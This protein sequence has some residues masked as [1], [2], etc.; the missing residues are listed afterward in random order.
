MTENS[1][2]LITETRKMFIFW[3]NAAYMTD[4]KGECELETSLTFNVC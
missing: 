3:E 2:G 4:E 1:H